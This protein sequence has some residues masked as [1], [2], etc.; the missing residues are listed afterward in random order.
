MKTKPTAPQTI[1][2]YIAGF[3]ADVQA[4]LKKIRQTI[5]KAAPQAEETLSYQMPT[6]TLKGLRQA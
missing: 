4:I 1:D 2:D 6:F 5:K 3:P